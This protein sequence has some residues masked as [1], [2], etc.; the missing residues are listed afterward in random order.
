VARRR[1]SDNLAAVVGRN[2]KEFRIAKGWSQE[3]LAEAAEMDRS[4]LA[5][6]E[7]G[8]RNPSL[9]AL[10]RLADALSVRPAQLFE[11]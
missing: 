4:Y 5:G 1:H 6:I 7:V 8:V 2:I 11:P 9:N 10:A 3:R